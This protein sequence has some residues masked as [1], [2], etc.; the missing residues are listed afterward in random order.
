MFFVQFERVSVSDGI[1]DC[2]CVG[3]YVRVL[4]INV[5]IFAAAFPLVG[6]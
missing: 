5:N 2:A 6:F 4:I 1:C 3:F